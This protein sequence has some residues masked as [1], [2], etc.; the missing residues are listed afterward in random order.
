[1]FS[2]CHV[3]SFLLSF[4][5]LL[6]LAVTARP[7]WQRNASTG[8]RTLTTSTN[9]AGTV[10]RA[11]ISNPPINLYNFALIEDLASFL[12]A[13]NTSA[14]TATPPPKVVIFAS[15]DPTFFIAHIDLHTLSATSPY[16]NT[17][18]SATL[19][20]LY[21]QTVDLLHT[22]PIIFVGEINGR[23]FGAGNEIAVQLDMR[24]AGPNT[25]FGSIEVAIGV[26]HG[27]GGIQYLTR[28]IGPGRAAE[29][30]LSARDVDAPT[31]A[32]YGW[33]N[34]AYASAEELREAVD[35]LAERIATFPAEALNGTKAG[36]RE[37]GP[38]KEALDSDLA[39]FARLN[40]KEEAQGAVGR[41]LSLSED[42]R[43]GR[44]ELGLME[45]LVE[46]WPGEDGE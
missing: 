9:P 45:D 23:A 5:A 38:S 4:S 8:H 16:L 42:E 2:P 44:F 6:P 18:Y 27:N 41:W 10:L 36:I 12:L 30:L 31:A 15:S 11:L 33:V 24:F 40:G 3:L 1:M 35:A 34:R 29:Y 46:L 28:L 19:L 17:T 37:S 26:T 22:L 25:R 20:G 14:S 7:P 43:R 13:L 32:A 21:K 39:T